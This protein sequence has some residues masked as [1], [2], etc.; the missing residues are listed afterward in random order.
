MTRYVTDDPVVNR[1]L[2]E[3]ESERDAERALADDLAAKLVRLRILAAF[4][5]GDVDELADIDDSLARYRKA[6]R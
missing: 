6:R 3:L 1:W 4:W 5:F 2:K